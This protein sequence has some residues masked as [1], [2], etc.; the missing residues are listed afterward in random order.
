[1]ADEEEVEPVICRS[2]T[3]ARRHPYVIGVIGGWVSPWPSTAAQLVAFIGSAVLLLRTRVWW[4]P[5]VPGFGDLL[6]TFGVPIYLWW[7]ARYLRIQGRSPAKAL[8]GG[9]NYVT[10]PT[11]GVV[12]GRPYRERH[13][14]LDGG[15][16]FCKETR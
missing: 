14:Q 1:M 11:G 10:R 15:A 7:A 13:G 16:C 4:G 12:N 8:I 9:L 6:V 2:Y 5:I 3:R